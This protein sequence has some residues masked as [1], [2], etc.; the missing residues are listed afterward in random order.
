MTHDRLKEVGAFLKRQR[1]A[2][3]L[4]P[5]DLVTKGL[6]K[7]TIR[8]I[9]AGKDLVRE[10]KVR[11]YC[12]QLGYEFREVCEIL[13]YRDMG[14]LK[15]RL[16]EIEFDIDLA[17]NLDQS[18]DE[19]KEIASNL[20]PDHPYIPSVHF[21]KAKAHFYAG[22]YEKAENEAVTAIELSQK[23]QDTQMNIESISRNILSNVYYWQNRLKDSFEEIERAIERFDTSGDNH[24]RYHMMLLN[25]AVLLHKLGRLRDAEDILDYLLK[26]GKNIDRAALKASVYE[27]QAEV[28]RQNKQYE[29][30][31]QFA[32]EGLKIVA[33]NQLYSRAFELWIVVGNIYEDLGD[34]DSAKSAY[35]RALKLEGKLPDSTMIGTGY[36]CLGNLYRRQKDFKT[37]KI[38]FDKALTFESDDISFID[39][40]VGIAQLF[41]DQGMKESAIRP[42]QKALDMATIQGMTQKQYDICLLLTQCFEGID[43][44]QYINHLKLFHRI[45]LELKREA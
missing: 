39:T 7:T 29:Q 13:G 22:R 33:M 24:D 19:L 5:E 8:R 26:E 41:L 30:A 4:R 11:L 25:K 16:E 20:E 40:L 43:N 32:R 2:K 1:E 37:A 38:Y 18:F 6:S 42:L 28:K 9:E 27:L 31:L 44:V 12:Q 45:S 10:G 23:H 21:L 17:I 36:A 14:R 15:K 3:G 35:L 34:P